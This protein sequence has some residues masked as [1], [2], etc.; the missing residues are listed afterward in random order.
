MVAMPQY[1]CAFLRDARGWWLLQLR[2][3]DILL[4]PGQLT[5]FGGRR[6]GDEAP[7]ACL[8]REL[9]E[10]L[11]WCPRQL[12][13]ALQLWQGPR[14]IAGFFQGTL[15]VPLTQLRLEAGYRALMAP[16]AA[17]PGL[18]LSPWHAQAIDACQRGR[19]LLQ[20]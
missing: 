1:A 15:D 12:T 14:L 10:E 11:G 13:P 20:V 3:M 8:R 6:E 5:C 9:Q 16:G 18:P 4:A 7:E 17:H 19:A 2:P